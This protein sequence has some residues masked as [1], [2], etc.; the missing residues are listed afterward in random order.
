MKEPKEPTPE[1]K[2]FRAQQVARLR[3]ELSKATEHDQQRFVR[4]RPGVRERCAEIASA[5]RRRLSAAGFAP[6]ETDTL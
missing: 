5:A 1:L 2:S 4:E 6:T 3:F